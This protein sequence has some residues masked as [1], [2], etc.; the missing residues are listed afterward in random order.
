MRISDWSS[1]VCSSDLRADVIVRD[2]R[3]EI[4]IERPEK[5]L[6]GDELDLKLGEPLEGRNA[7]VG[8]GHGDFGRAAEPRQFVVA[9]AELVAATI[10]AARR[11]H[12]AGARLVYR[13]AHETLASLLRDPV[14]P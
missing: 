6:I 9:P 12:R 1:D 11:P 4:E 3:R 14:Y 2:P 10:N 13:S 8:I 7:A 5:G